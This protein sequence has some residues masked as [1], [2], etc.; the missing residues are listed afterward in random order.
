VKPI[1][2]PLPSQ[3]SEVRDDSAVVRKRFAVRADLSELESRSTNG[4][5]RRPHCTVAGV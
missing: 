2:S 1:T 5:V 4:M 3:T